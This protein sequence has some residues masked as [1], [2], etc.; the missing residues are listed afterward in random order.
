M[1]A[2]FASIEQR[3]NPAYQNKPLIVGGNPNGR[4]VVAAASYEAR[5]FGIR[6]AMSCFEAKQR[7]PEAIFVPPRFE[8]YRAVSEQIQEIMARLSPIIEPVSLDE[9]YLDV[10]HQDSHQGSATLMAVWLKDEIYRQTHLT[11]SAGI[12]YNKMLAKIASDINKP[13]GITLI[14]PNHAQALIDALPIEKFHGIGKASALKLHQANIYH[15][16]QLRQTPIE[17]LV[18][19]FGNKRGKFYHQIAHGIDEREVK[20]TRVRKSIGSETTFAEN[21]QQAEVLLDKIFQQNQEAFEILQHKQFQAHTITLKIKYADFSII[22][23]SH[24]LKTPF[25]DA[26]HSFL[27]LK[28]LFEQA[29]KEKPIRL[30]GVT[31]SNFSKHAP[32]QPSL[33]D[34]PSV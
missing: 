2:F 9:A 29:P 5:R 24:S 32:K 6:S 7:C 10:S 27:W 12:S 19:M 8:T 31:F 3:D 1:D 22:T 25:K 20:A 18:A 16:L 15:G 28:K 21:L 17:H 30:V 11:A 26:H 33:F 23:R 14:P 13:N 34:E 4:G